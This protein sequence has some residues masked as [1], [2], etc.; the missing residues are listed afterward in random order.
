[1]LNFSKDLGD[2]K[3]E[4][5]RWTQDN[6]LCLS[7]TYEVVFAQVFNYGK[8]EGKSLSRT[9]QVTGDNVLSIV[10]GVEAVLLDWEQI[11]DALLFELVNGLWH[12]LWEIFKFS[13]RWF[14]VWQF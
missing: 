11:N 14:I 2:L 10:D 12:D 5:S 9:G 1:M 3:R 4:F 13:I 7:C 8:G 6:S